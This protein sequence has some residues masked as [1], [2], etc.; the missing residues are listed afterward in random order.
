MFKKEFK[1]MVLSSA[2]FVAL[3]LLWNWG[4]YSGLNGMYQVSVQSY[5]PLCILFS[6]T[7]VGYDLI[8]FSDVNFG[9]VFLTLA[10]IINLY[11]GFKLQ[12]NMKKA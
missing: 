10:V 1:L 7:K 4:E 3:Y 11:L 2:F 12:N 8:L 6:G 9:F 5:F